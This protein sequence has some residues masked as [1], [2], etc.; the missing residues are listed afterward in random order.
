MDK[1]SYIVP[2]STTIVSSYYPTSNWN[3]GQW[4][5]PDLSSLLHLSEF[6]SPI[7]LRS[8]S[9]VRPPMSAPRELKI[10]G[11]VRVSQPSPAPARSALSPEKIV[12][13]NKTEVYILGFSFVLV[14]GYA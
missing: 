5:Y 3:N 2:P 13:N 14:M 7:E 10:K 8:D 11:S 9:I 12:G 1:F 4:N 6:N